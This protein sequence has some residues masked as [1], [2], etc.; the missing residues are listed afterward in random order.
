MAA[1]R[2]AGVVNPNDT[3][4]DSMIDEEPVFERN[5]DGER[6]M[7]PIHFLA[8]PAPNPPNHLD[9]FR[10][11]SQHPH[12]WRAWPEPYDLDLGK[13][14]DLTEDVNLHPTVREAA[15]ALAGAYRERCPDPAPT[16]R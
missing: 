1:S 11:D 13:I 6:L 3:W 9:T 12:H 4:D 10:Q 8:P 5:Q 15:D 7:D 14:G 2:L 16:P